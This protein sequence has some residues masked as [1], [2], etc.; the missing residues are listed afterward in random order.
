MQ[1]ENRE[2]IWQRHSIKFLEMAFRTD[3]QEM[4]PDADGR[5]SKASDCGDTIEFFLVI[6]DRRIDTISYTLKGCINTN[7]CANA[8]VELAGGRRLE[9]AWAITPRH[10][11]DFLESLG[12][13]HFHCAELAV[14]ALN[15]ALTDAREM[16]HTTW[17]KMY[18]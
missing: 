1:S 14:A 13:P 8:V 3:R 10:V 5:G 12:E 15:A 6:R 17:K 11:A 4:I 16:Q 7:A 18:R 2:E 9:E